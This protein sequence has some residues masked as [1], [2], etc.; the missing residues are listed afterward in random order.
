MF[1][2]IQRRYRARCAETTI[3]SRAF[4]IVRISSGDGSKLLSYSISSTEQTCTE[5]T[6]TEQNFDAATRYFDADTGPSKFC[7]I[8]EPHVTAVLYFGCTG[9]ELHRLTPG[10]IL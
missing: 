3:G 7:S 6:C 2:Q 4:S 8:K 1:L 10:C 9:V 5:Q